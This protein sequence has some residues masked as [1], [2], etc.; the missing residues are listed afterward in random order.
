MGR[1]EI[2]EKKEEEEN[3]RAVLISIARLYFKNIDISDVH[4]KN[5]DN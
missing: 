5:V 2:L 4:H 1:K 3:Y